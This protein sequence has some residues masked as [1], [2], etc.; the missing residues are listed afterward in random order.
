MYLLQLEAF[1]GQYTV[2]DTVEIRSSD[3][4]GILFGDDFDDNDISDWE[5]IAGSGWSASSGKA[6][7]LVDITTPAAIA[8]GGFSVSSG[9]ISLEFDL[10]VSGA[11][12]PGNAALVDAAGNGVFL[13]SY[14]G[15]NYV[16]IGAKLTDDNGLTGTVGDQ[17]DIAADPSAGITIR[18]E[19]NL[20][21]GEVKGYI[22]GDLKNTVTLDLTGVGA[23]TNVVLQAKKNWYLDNV[24]LD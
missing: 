14:V 1:D 6:T 8:K 10:T 7:K 22:D 13:Q 24:I 12:R 15:D 4:S 21:T 9:T 18:Y 20:D 19:V 3:T 16:E 5:I 11:W 17:T 2:S 23:I